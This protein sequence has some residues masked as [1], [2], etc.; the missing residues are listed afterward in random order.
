ML[1]HPT[2]GAGACPPGPRSEKPGMQP[3]DPGTVAEFL[4]DALEAAAVAR[5]VATL[6]IP[7][8]RSPGPTLAALARLC[9]NR[10]RERLHLLWVDERAVPPG[11]PERNDAATLAAWQS[12]GPLPAHVHPMPAEAPDLEAA[13]VAYAAVL[14]AVTA[15][16]GLDAVL[17]GIG[18]D[19]H[20]ASLFPQHAALAD[21]HPVLAITDA[22]K[23]P[24]RRLT[25]SLG[26][27]RS[28]GRTAVLATGPAKGRVARAAWN[29]PNRAIPASLLAA[30]RCSWFLDDAAAAAAAGAEPQGRA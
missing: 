10:L 6:A 22:P 5:G 29:G 18:E 2:L 16:R 15:G 24:P 4:V 17:L 13:A 20:V 3:Y 7:G 28:A 8:G 12:G 19:G 14:A 9:D 23:P 27:L 26:V 25:V 21:P 11:D 1:L 30:D